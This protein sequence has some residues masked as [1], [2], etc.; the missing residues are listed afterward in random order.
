MLHAPKEF[1][2]ESSDIWET[3]TENKDKFYTKNLAAFIG[4]TRKQAAKYGSRLNNA[5]KVLDFLDD[6]CNGNLTADS[7]L[8]IKDVWDE[9]PTGD[10]IIK[11]PYDNDNGMRTYEVCGRKLGETSYLYYVY[12]IIKKFYDNCR[13]RAEKAARN[14]GIDYKAIS[15]AFRAAYQAKDILI[16]GNISFPLR[17]ANFLKEVKLGK[18]DY[19]NEIIPKLD[20]LIEEVE[21]LSKNSNYPMIVDRHFWNN[22]LIETLDRELETSLKRSII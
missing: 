2:I 6:K 19:Q 1:L 7:Y 10:F 16:N 5:K 17:E 8:K 11:Y 15:H 13:I 21:Q 20:G 12:D 3:I 22:F 9:L 4:Y 14:E 18:L